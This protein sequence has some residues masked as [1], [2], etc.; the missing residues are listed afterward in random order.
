MTDRIPVKGV[1]NGSNE[2]T[3]LS[4]F[5]NTDTIPVSNGG[6]GAT[7]ANGAL[8]N[9]LPSQTGNTG[10]YLTTDGTNTNWA[11]VSGGGSTTIDLVS[12]TFASGL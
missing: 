10:K 2:A 5:T 1:F 7:S 11:T 9:L 12:Y 3:G 4:E 6:T 8:T